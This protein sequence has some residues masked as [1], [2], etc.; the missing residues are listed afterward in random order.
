M[1]VILSQYYVLQ[2]DSE[3]FDFRSLLVGFRRTL[4]VVKALKT[5][6]FFKLG[7]NEGV[8]VNCSFTLCWALC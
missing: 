4:V 3:I 5:C 1:N 2:K 8:G 6:D 7:D